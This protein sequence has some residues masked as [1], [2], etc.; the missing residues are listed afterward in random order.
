MEGSIL[1]IRGEPAAWKFIEPK[2]NEY[3]A[4][5]KKYGTAR[6]QAGI[7]P[8]NRGSAGQEIRET[9]G[10]QIRETILGSSVHGYGRTQRK[11]SCFR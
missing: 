10:K 5:E 1:F 11:I 4:K 2:N 7:Y 3:I 9:K 6:I 8:E